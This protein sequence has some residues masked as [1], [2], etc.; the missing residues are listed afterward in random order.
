[1]SLLDWQVGVA[2]V[3]V[4]V[5]DDPSVECVTSDSDGRY[6]L[7]GVPGS[8][9]VLIKYTKTGYFPA[10][11]TV[12]TTSGA[13]DVG[14]FPAPTNT[15][16]TGFAAAVGVTIDFTK[17]HI[18]TLALTGGSTGSTGQDAVWATL[19]PSSGLGP[20]Y[21]N[22]SYLPDKS[23]KWTSTAGAGLFAN[24]DEGDAEVEMEHFSKTC[25]RYPTSWPGAT[26]T[27]SK[28]RVVAGYVTGGAILVCP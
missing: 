9:D 2:G 20:F 8:S 18:L 7:K 21:A 6:A 4:C 23:L 25:A 11:V 17:G 27:S 13:M 14:K 22:A 5:Y 28:V 26:T 19:T 16:A 10:L 15:E 1:V 24:V 12:R 3:T